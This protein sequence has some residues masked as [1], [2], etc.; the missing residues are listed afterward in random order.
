MMEGSGNN[1]NSRPYSSKQSFATTGRSLRIPVPSAISRQAKRSAGAPAVWTKYAVLG[2][3]T[4]QRSEKAGVQGPVN[5]HGFDAPDRM[6][7]GIRASGVT[8]V[9]ISTCSRRAALLLDNLSVDG[10]QHRTITPLT[11]SQ[12]PGFVNVRLLRITPS[13]SFAAGEPTVCHRIG[14]DSPGSANRSTRPQLSSRPGSCAVGVPPTALATASANCTGCPRPA[15][16]LQ[17]GQK[18]SIYQR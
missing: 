12:L 6:A 9:I 4:G 5:H 15:G 10:N 16:N 8:A 17:T 1:L 13:T 18:T 3:H 7:L 2:G 11:A 14:N